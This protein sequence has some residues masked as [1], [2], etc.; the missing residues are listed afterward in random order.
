M[1]ILK[2]YIKVFFADKW[3]CFKPAPKGG[4]YEEEKSKDAPV[5][6]IVNDG[7]HSRAGN[8]GKIY[9][10]MDQYGYYVRCFK[11]K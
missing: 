4:I 7:S 1:K 5:F 11:D 6:I 10:N 8:I 3:Q 2:F 9:V